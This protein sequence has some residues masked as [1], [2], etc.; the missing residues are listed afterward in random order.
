[1]TPEISGHFDPG[2]GDLAHFLSQAYDLK[3]IADYDVGPDTG[4]SLDRAA[5]AIET[6]GHLL[7][8]SPSC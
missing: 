1:M 5:A 4:V 8:V 3:S 7:T 6:A 2:L